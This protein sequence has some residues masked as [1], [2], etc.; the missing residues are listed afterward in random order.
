MFRQVSSGKSLSQ[1]PG[2]KPGFRIFAAD[3]PANYRELVGVEPI[4]AYVRQS[5]DVRQRQA[6]L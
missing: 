2:L 1:K 6:A 4:V 3:A 5:I